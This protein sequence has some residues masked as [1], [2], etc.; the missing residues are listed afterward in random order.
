MKSF[1][2]W[3]KHNRSLHEKE[4]AQKH[5]RQE[6]VSQ[7]VRN[8]IFVGLCI[9]DST[10]VNPIDSIHFDD[11]LFWFEF[12]HLIVGKGNYNHKEELKPEGVLLDHPS[13]WRLV[14]KVLC[15]AFFI[16]HS[17]FD[18]SMDHRFVKGH[19]ILVLLPNCLKIVLEDNGDKTHS[20][21]DKDN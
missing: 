9:V 3:R 13:Y 18:L 21:Y 17:D 14:L 7:E 2:D 8:F 5:E 12:K 10:I 1:I 11:R 19:W 16:Y 20:R 15:Q 4:E 6:E